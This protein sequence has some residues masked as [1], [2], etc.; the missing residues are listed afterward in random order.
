MVRCGLE[1]RFPLVLAERILDAGA[2]E[3]GQLEQVLNGF[4][5]DVAVHLVDD[6]GKP[7]FQPQRSCEVFG[8]E[9]QGCRPRLPELS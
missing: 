7:F 5:N 4:L 6:V 2:T 1:V 8:S 9:S 3:Q